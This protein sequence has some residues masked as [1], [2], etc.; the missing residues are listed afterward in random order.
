[1]AL[2]FLRT[3]LSLKCAK[4]A[5]E[6]TPVAAAEKIDFRVEKGFGFGYRAACVQPVDCGL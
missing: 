1:M 2:I 4:R 6:G 3:F 5:P